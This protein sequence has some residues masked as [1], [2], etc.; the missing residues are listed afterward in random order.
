MP[1]QRP[2]IV[3]YTDDKTIKKMRI[4]A[5][6]SNRSVSQ[7]VGFLIKK[8]ISQYEKENGEIEILE[9]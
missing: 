8:R 5:E 9:E 7:E 4:I 1:S 6:D 2:K 3:T